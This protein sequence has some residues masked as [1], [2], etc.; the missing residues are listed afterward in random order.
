MLSER[1]Q[2]VKI[3][4]KNIFQTSLTTSEIND[5]SKGSLALC[6]SIYKLLSDGLFLSYNLQDIFRYIHTNLAH[7]TANK[8]FTMDAMDLKQK[9]K[10]L[11]NIPTR[12]ESSVKFILNEKLI[13]D[14][15]ELMTVIP[16]EKF[17]NEKVNDLLFKDEEMVFLKSLVTPLL[18]IN[19][20]FQMPNLEEDDIVVTSTRKKKKKKK[21]K[22]T[23]S[24]KNLEKSSTTTTDTTEE[25]SS[26]PTSEKSFSGSPITPAVTTPHIEKRSNNPIEN[27][28]STI[29]AT[30]IKQNVTK[31]GD[32]T[33]LSTQSSLTSLTVAEEPVDLL[34]DFNPYEGMTKHQ[35]LEHMP[36]N[37]KREEAESPISSLNTQEKEIMTLMDEKQSADS[38]RTE[39]IESPMNAEYSNTTLSPHVSTTTEITEPTTIISSVVSLETQTLTPQTENST[40]VEDQ[41]LNEKAPLEKDVSVSDTKEESNIEK[42][43]EQAQTCEEKEEGTTTF[44]SFKIPEEQVSEKSTQNSTDIQTIITAPPQDA[45]HQFNTNSTHHHSFI[46][47]EISEQLKHI[48]SL[49]MNHKYSSIHFNTPVDDKVAEFSDYYKFTKKPMDFNTIK[50][51]LESHKYKTVDEFIRDVQLV[52]NNTFMYHLESAPQVKMAHV[53]SDIFERELDLAIPSWRSLDLSPQMEANSHSEDDFDRCDSEHS[54]EGTLEAY[55]TP[56]STTTKD[57]CDFFP[58]PPTYRLEQAEIEPQVQQP[59]ASNISMHSLSMAK[60]VAGS[61]QENS[62]PLNRVDFEV[63]SLLKDTVTNDSDDD[64]SDTLSEFEED[65]KEIDSCEEDNQDRTTITTT[66]TTQQH[67]TS[68]TTMDLLRPISTIQ[69][70]DDSVCKMLTASEMYSFF[71]SY[72]DHMLKTNELNIALKVKKDRYENMLERIPHVKNRDF[73]L[74]DSLPPTTVLMNLSILGEKLRY[75]ED[76]LKLKQVQLMKEYERQVQAIQKKELEFEEL[77]KQL[78]EKEQAWLLEKSQLLTRVTQLEQLL[79]EKNTEIEELKNVPLLIPPSSSLQPQQPIAQEERI[80]RQIDMDEFIL[81]EK[82]VVLP[83]SQSSADVT[84]LK[85]T[86]TTGQKS[87]PSTP[88]SGC[89]QDDIHF[90]GGS[91]EDILDDEA[92]TEDEMSEVSSVVNVDAMDQQQLILEEEDCIRLSPYQ[93]QDQTKQIQQQDGKCPCGRELAKD[94]GFLRKPRYCHYTNKYYCMKCHSNSFNEIIP[95]KILFNWDFKPYRVC[96]E[97]S[98]YLKSIYN[99]PIICVSAVKPTLFDENENLGMARM[100]RKRLIIQWEYISRCPLKDNLITQHKLKHKLHYVTDTEMYSVKNLCELN[101]KQNEAP[102]LKKLSRLFHVFSDHI[103]NQCGFCKTKAKSLCP[104]C[105][106][107]TPIYEFNISQVIK[108]PSCKLVFHKSCFVNKKGVVACPVCS[109]D[110]E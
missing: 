4:I 63:D 31:Q 92:L 3:A 68:A 2:T 78:H 5:D 98:K 81:I 103:V 88:M 93:K 15:I 25:T 23:I 27:V 82:V 49:L 104:N 70:S 44:E 55:F 71:S 59:Q 51:K 108:C 52:F 37:L 53:L 14:L 61:N 83:S 19:F 35:A 69:F 26:T 36:E 18:T 62:L 50:T 77:Q 21:D 56:K 65:A 1:L 101:G 13:V 87:I 96:D 105:K 85:T 22:K 24:T 102:F 91:N 107:D 9:I 40:R 94:Y 20:R 43:N 8:S 47:S 90:M 97:A 6:E 64:D 30:S 29:E 110:D 76:R 58:T 100:I 16:K 84:T 46:S 7:L 75:H 10:Q 38:S 73:I 79:V 80:D 32:L 67:T 54:N 57:H 99:Q 34:E 89:H 28:V 74:E 109:N 60:A 95:A 41:E 72:L 33:P 39:I 42:I 11:Q 45:E 86:T 66:E 12:D 17:Y 106:N 48:L